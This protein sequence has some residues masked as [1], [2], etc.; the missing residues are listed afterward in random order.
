MTPLELPTD[1][2]RP[3]PLSYRGDS[4]LRA[5]GG[6]RRVPQGPLAPAQRHPLHD[7]A[8]R[9]P[10]P[11]DALHG[12]G[13]HRRRHADR[14]AQPPRARGPHR[15]LRQHAGHARRSGRQPD[16]SAN[17]WP[18]PASTP[19][20]PTPTRTC[21]SR[22]WSRSSE[23]ERDMSRNPLF[24]VM[25]A[26]QNTAEAELR[27]PGLACERL[28]LHNGTAKFDLTLSLTETDG[29]LEGSSNTAATCSMPRRSGAWRGITAGCSRQSW[30]IPGEA[31]TS[32]RC[33][34]PRSGICCRRV[35]RHA[36]RLPEE[37]LHPGPVP[38][39]GRASPGRS[40]PGAG[41]TS[42]PI[43]NSTRGPTDWPATSAAWAPAPRPRSASAWSARP[44]WWSACS[45]SSRQ[46]PLTCR[47]IRATPRS[48]WSSW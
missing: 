43:G 45:A 34:P 5:A 7:A 14:R 35:E 40:G 36:V 8:G 46:V 1:R 12:P 24:Q 28:P 11:A 31:S 4:A 22:S 41:T 16:A 33:S 13:R 42:S 2:P 9:V 30:P 29:A 10:G 19:S 21:P 47:W 25:F 18:G 27:L 48:A 38:G 15:L 39:A 26:L 3:L 44:T 6:A 32:C 37:P 17:C 20:T 23:P